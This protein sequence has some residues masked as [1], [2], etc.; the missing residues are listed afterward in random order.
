M[1]DFSVVVLEINE[2]VAQ[3]LLV[4]ICEQVRPRGYLVSMSFKLCKEVI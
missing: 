2:V 4:M 3:T 1:I